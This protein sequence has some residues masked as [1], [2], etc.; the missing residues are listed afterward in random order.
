MYV[1]NCTIH[2]PEVVHLQRRGAVGAARREQR[3]Q[4]LQQQNEVVR[5][6]GEDVPQ[7]LRRELLELHV[8]RQPFEALKGGCGFL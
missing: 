8:V 3:E 5:R 6:G 1:I 7:L 2:A 4:P